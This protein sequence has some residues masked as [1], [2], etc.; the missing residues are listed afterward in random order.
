MP[1]DSFTPDFFTPDQATDTG[2]DSFISDQDLVKLSLSSALGA[3]GEVQKVLPVIGAYQ[4]ERAEANLRDLLGR[5]PTGPREIRP[6]V[7]SLLAPQPAQPSIPGAMPADVANQYVREQLR[8]AYEP[9]LR[10]PTFGEELKMAAQDI[11][12]IGRAFDAEA[13]TPA[14]VIQEKMLPEK[15]TRPETSMEGI[16]AGLEDTLRGLVS[17]ENIG[18]IL[19][20]GGAAEIL[21]AKELA[22]AG[23]GAYEAAARYATARNLA[24]KAISGYFGVGG[25]EAAR[26][27]FPTIFEPGK[28]LPE[29][30]QAATET[31]GSALVGLGALGHAV[32]SPLIETPLQARATGEFFGPERELKAADIMAAYPDWVRE[33]MAQRSF[34][35]AFGDL[36]IE[37]QN[38]ILAE[39]PKEPGWVQEAIALREKEREAKDAQ[40]IRSDQGPARAE[41][42]IIK[43]REGEGGPDLERPTS[44]RPEPVVAGKE[45]PK[46]EEKVAPVTREGWTFDGEKAGGKISF[47]RT[48]KG[49]ESTLTFDKNA[50]VT[51]IEAALK[52]KEVEYQQAKLTDPEHVAKLDGIQFMADL[53][54]AGWQ[55]SRAAKEAA[56][57]LWA[58]GEHRLDWLAEREKDARKVYDD[59]GEMTP[60]NME[61]KA[62]ASYKAQY[63]NEIQRFLKAAKE[64]EE[65]KRPVKEIMD[66]H[67]MREKEIREIIAGGLTAAPPSPAVPP[68]AP[69]PPPEAAIPPV[70]KKRGRPKKATIAPSNIPPVVESLPKAPP[71][72]LA[73][74]MD[75]LKKAADEARDRLKKKGVKFNLGPFGELENIR[76]YAIIGVH[77]LSEFGFDKA[78]WIG[79]MIKDFGDRIRPHLNHIFQES[80]KAFRSLP[81]ESQSMINEKIADT[82]ERLH[83]EIDKL[84]AAPKTKESAAQ[85]KSLSNQLLEM[86]ADHPEA[87]AIRDQRKSKQ[88]AQQSLREEEAAVTSLTAK[89]VEEATS[90]SLRK[91]LTELN[92][93]ID[94]LPRSNIRPE[95]RDEW[96]QEWERQKTLI[97]DQLNR[98]ERGEKEAKEF[99]KAT[100]TQVPGVKITPEIAPAEYPPN[101]AREYFKREI[102]KLEQVGKLTAEQEERLARLK[103]LHDEVAKLKE[104]TP[105]EAEVAKVSLGEQ[106]VQRIEEAGRQAS[107]RI[108]KRGPGGTTLSMAGTGDIERFLANVVDLSIMGAAKL[109][110]YGLDKARFIKEMRRTFGDW[111]A[112]HMDDL[113]TASVHMLNR[114]GE[115]QRAKQ[116]PI[117]Q[118][119]AEHTGL[120]ASQKGDLAK[121]IEALQNALKTVRAIKDH[122]EGGPKMSTKE[123]KVAD[124]FLEAD[125]NKIRESLTEYVKQ[126]LPVSERGRFITAINNATKRPPLLT[127]NPE[128]MYRRAA[129]VAAAISD[130]SEETAK[131]RLINRIGLMANRAME[132]SGVDIGYKQRIKAI[133]DDLLLSKPTPATIRRL[134]ALREFADRMT[135]QGIDPGIPS[136]V[137]SSLDVLAKTPAKDLPLDVLQAIHDQMALNVELGRQKVKGFKAVWNMEKDGKTGELEKEVTRPWNKAL[138]QKVLG[139]NTTF[140]TKMVNLIRKLQNAGSMVDRLILPIDA[141]MDMLGEAKGKYDGWLFRNIRNPLDLAFNRMLLRRDH[142]LNPVRELIKRYNFGEKDGEI[143]GVYA[144]NVQEGGRERM[145]NMLIP[146]NI[147][148]PESSKE[149]SPAYLRARQVATAEIDRVLRKMTPQHLKVY[150]LMRSRLEEALPLVQALMHRLYNI[151]VRPVE[152]YFPMPREWAEYKIREPGKEMR[153]PVSGKPIEEGDLGNWRELSRDFGPAPGAKIERGYTI[154]RV[155]NALS[156]IK[157]NAFNIYERHV[158]DVAHLIETQRDLKMAWE[159]T[160]T[161]EF[162]AKYGRDGLTAIQGWL[163]V[164]ARQ[165]HMSGLHRLPVLDWFRRKTS[166]GVIGFRL[167][168]N[169]VHSS[170]IPLGWARA[171]MEYYPRAAAVVFTNEAQDFMR[172]YFRETFERGGGEISITEAEKGPLTRA[173]FWVARTI[174]QFN[175]QA[176]TLGVYMRLIEQKTGRPFSFDA[177]IDPAAQ[178]EAMTLSRRAVASPLAKDVSLSL[179]R[180]ALLNENVSLSRTVMQ[181]QNIFQDQ[182]SNIRHDLLAAGLGMGKGLEANPEYAAKMALS[183]A[184]MLVWEAGIRTGGT[185]FSSAVTGN[186]PKKEEGFGERMGLDLLRR[187]PFMAQLM[188][189]AIYHDT[190]IPLVDTVQKIIVEGTH[191]ITSKKAMARQRAAARAITG[192]AQAVGVPGAGQVGEL[193]AKGL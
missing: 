150:R 140:D 99:A 33:G 74:A 188:A 118:I 154:T 48:V 187:F 175:A 29:R 32:T 155:P 136:E 115:K 7:Q 31:A 42:D 173:G 156:A 116:T 128:M 27:Q 24:A 164:F 143:I 129:Q 19:A 130:W 5:E 160:Q 44:G 125:A 139:E 161:P 22:A 55:P 103:R 138:M 163:D 8:Q 79:E 114:F 14:G 72:E 83:G 87:N 66:R 132:S 124:D 6:D 37:Q 105:E 145:I 95:M 90:A 77:K 168:S 119:I 80:L 2:R 63:F 12:L 36:T 170:N 70:P 92:E 67:G 141:M 112:P 54:N 162:R 152:N 148:I 47:T 101:I 71:A 86:I 43:E 13:G 88:L 91:R 106:I 35:K 123:V 68:P 58:S 109:A 176:T 153:E 49:E 30:L 102:A 46:T 186:F 53:R 147:P 52:G 193:V 192:A 81:Y 108:K 38:K 64:L 11:P 57:E 190:G 25:E 126:Q 134:E 98:R 94:G 183:I 23:K 169:V 10:A 120:D 179:S 3:T 180:G 21:R 135:A 89:T 100:Q 121:T 60:K 191:A 149:A 177:A 117:Q 127:G 84:D 69:A 104:P 181:F 65:G 85:R 110:R 172:K 107:E 144:H 137:L 39:A 131:K 78:K 4:Q 142:M 122:F 182:W 28:S 73:P 96:R 76:D 171:G 56:T 167:V 93:L 15:L 17:P 1:K 26:R 75:L 45:A 157:T 9:K 166:V 18:L 133:M 41:R 82:I 184:A 51:Q 34:G 20:S 62:A 185:T 61:V 97:N 50:P 16:R 165:G 151:E 111:I 174:D 146:E 59:L 113:Y 159:L 178:A 40:R 158:Q 189:I